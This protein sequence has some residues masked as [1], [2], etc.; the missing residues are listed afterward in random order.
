MRRSDPDTRLSGAR[1]CDR[2]CSGRGPRVLRSS[3]SLTMA[4]RPRPVVLLHGCGGTP[5]AT[6]EATGMV[7]MLERTGHK[8]LLLSLPGHGPTPSFSGPADFADLAGLVADVLPPT[9]F[10]AIGYSLGGKLLLELA[11]RMPSRIGR[12]VLGGIGD[13]VFAPEAVAE[14]A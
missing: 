5:D 10:D 12:L 4:P 14:A 7:E 13:N 8:P 2:Q 1:Y 6:F 9:S 3:N 11:I